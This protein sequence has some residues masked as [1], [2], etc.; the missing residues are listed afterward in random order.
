MCKQFFSNEIHQLSLSNVLSGGKVI[1]FNKNLML[2][3]I[4][5]NDVS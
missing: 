1:Y 5:I 3:E 2:T 4:I